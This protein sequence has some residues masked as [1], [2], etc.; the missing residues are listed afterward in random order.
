MPVLIEKVASIEKLFPLLESIALN[1][2]SL[3]LELRGWVNILGLYVQSGLVGTEEHLSAG[4]KYKKYFHAFCKYTL[5]SE[6]DADK[7]VS[8]MMGD[9]SRWEVKKFDRTTWEE[10]FAHLVEPTFE[11]VWYVAVSTSEDAIWKEGESFTEQSIPKLM[12]VVNHFKSTREWLGLYNNQCAT[13]G[14]RVN[15][16]KYFSCSPCP[17]CGGK[18]RE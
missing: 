14:R 3:P 1:K 7:M 8:T 18:I 12:N 10:R 6:S 2:N 15:F 5:D 4:G 13:C 11:I 16:W 17:H 9:F